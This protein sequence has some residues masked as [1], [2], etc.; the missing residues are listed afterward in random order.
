MGTLSGDRFQIICNAVGEGGFTVSI[1]E[2]IF[3]CVLSLEQV[4]FHSFNIINYLSVLGVISRMGGMF[5]SIMNIIN[6][7][8]DLGVISLIGGTL[9]NM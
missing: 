9:N 8:N 4:L 3:Q 6:C 7:M 1:S 2:T 5:H